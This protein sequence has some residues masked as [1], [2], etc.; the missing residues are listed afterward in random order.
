MR[1]PVVVLA[2]LV[3]SGSVP[4]LGAAQQNPAACE[5][6]A[7]CR[8]HALDAAARGEHET[9]HDFAWLA[10]RKGQP[11]D[12]ELMF[13]L[14][15]AQS[16][17][18]RPHDALVMLRRI[19][20]LGVMTD[21]DAHEDFRRVRALRGWPEVAAL[22]SAL[23][24]KKASAPAAALPESRPVAGTSRPPAPSMTRDAETAP[25]LLTIVRRSFAPVG[26]AYDSVSRR[27]IVGDRRANKLMVLDEEFRRVNDLAAAASA[28][29]FGLTAIQIDRRR[30]DLWVANARADGSETA[31]HRLQLISGRV[32]QV[33][34]LPA[35]YGP[36]A[37]ADIAVTAEGAIVALDAL[38]RRVF[39]LRAAAY[40]RALAIDAD[41]PLSV[42]VLDENIACIA[43]PDGLVRV[44]L[45]AQTSAPLRSRRGVLL[46]GFVHIRADRGALV[47]IQQYDAGHRVVRIR[48]DPA[49]ERAVSA[50]VVAE[51]PIADPTS[52]AIEGG[53]LHFLA[54]EPGG[55]TA[56]RHISLRPSR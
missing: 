23:R 56:M 49:R 20:E 16:L 2:F 27:F 30:G 5:T 32:L 47:G 33:F 17:S 11:N 38:G 18:G 15:R 45:A 4:E 7:A 43:T 6:V 22:I 31:L 28:G 8:Q 12:P 13:L 53:T 29:F 46:Q 9:F 24:E 35:E 10:V 52:I 42:A 3:A 36:A 25:P 41:T 26:L 1:T 14:A 21:A 50:H 51:V 39:L 37:F 48:L 55:G 34:R 54:R 40:Q 44:D 19:A